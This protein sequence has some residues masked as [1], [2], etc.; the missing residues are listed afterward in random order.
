MATI[1]TCPTCGATVGWAEIW[2]LTTNGIR[3]GALCKNCG[4]VLEVVPWRAYLA[5]GIAFGAGGGL[6]GILPDSGRGLRW[7][8]FL[9][10][11]TILVVALA[12]CCLTLVRLRVKNSLSLRQ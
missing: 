2:S 11:M 6:A 3:S 12:V 5:Y 9:E 1:R 4:V 10:A 7:I 8:H